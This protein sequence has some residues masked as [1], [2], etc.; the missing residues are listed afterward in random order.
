V[1]WIT[2]TRI[3]TD[4][5]RRKKNKPGEGLSEKDKSIHIFEIPYSGRGTMHLGERKF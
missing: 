5:D 4:S 1:A 2:P 3:V